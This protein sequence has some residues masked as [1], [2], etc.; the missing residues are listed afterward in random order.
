MIS[1]L[2]VKLFIFVGVAIFFTDKC[3]AQDKDLIWLSNNAG[4]FSQ[5]VQMKIM[6]AL[7]QTFGGRDLILTPNKS[8]HYG[9]MIVDMCDVF[10]L[11]PEIRC[12]S[13]DVTKNVKC[14]ENIN[15]GVLKSDTQHVCYKGQIPLFTAKTSRDAIVRAVNLP[16]PMKFNH[17]YDTLIRQFKEQLG[18]DKLA[19]YT[20]VHWRRGDQLTA[21]CAVKKDK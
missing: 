21:R 5:F 16:L 7:T 4:L 1:S 12:A 8:P 17:T 15:V 10:E 6:H 11:P 3:S 9:K 19:S 20:V 2:N 14:V 18:L 13:A